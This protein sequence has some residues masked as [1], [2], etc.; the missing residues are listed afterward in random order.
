MVNLFS[1]FF[2]CQSS[3]YNLLQMKQG[4]KRIINP[5]KTRFFK[6][7]TSTFKNSD[8]LIELSKK[9]QHEVKRILVT[10]PNHR[11]G[12]QLLITPLIQFLEDE[13]PQAKIDLVING[14]LAEILFAHYSNINQFYHLPKKPFKNLIEYFKVSLSIISNK[15]DLGIAGLDDSNSSKIF[16]KLSRAKHKIFNSGVQNSTTIHVAKEPIF[17][18]CSALNKNID[19]INYPKLKLK[20]TSEEIK[21]GHTIL[22][23]F[24][25]TNLNTIAVFTNATR[26]KKISKE[27]WAELTTKLEEKF[28]NYNILEILP[29]ENCSQLDFKY[30]H[31]LSSDLREIA[32]VIENC[33][34]FIG[35]D[36]GVT[37]LATATNTPTFGL[38]NGATNPKLYGPYGKHK[39]VVD[40]RTFSLDDMIKQIEKL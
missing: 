36:S 15:Y 16:I 28:T 27:W 38:F 6:L 17:N 4:L 31:Y 7:L 37:H 21:I 11:L 40:V 14:H 34:V 26:N 39:F 10:R 20:L 24:F 25:S 18:Y 3:D 29:K 19:D 33:F 12:N 23:S 13:Y 35:A 2:R 22:S 5:W 8:N 9:G 1:W 30:T 32:S